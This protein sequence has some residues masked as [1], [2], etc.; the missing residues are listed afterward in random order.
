MSEDDG[1]PRTRAEWD[2]YHALPAWEV[3]ARMGRQA[4]FRVHAATAGHAEEA[5]RAG[6]N[7]VASMDDLYDGDLEVEA[8]ISTR[9]V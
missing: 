9:Q 8:I 6:R 2:A 5:V 7:G 1:G 4:R 3:T